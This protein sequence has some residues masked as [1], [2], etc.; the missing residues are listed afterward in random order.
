MRCAE[1]RIVLVVLTVAAGFGHTPARADERASGLKSVLTRDFDLGKRRSPG[2]R[3]FE[4]V[5]TWISF[6]PDGKRA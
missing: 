5:T 4:M 1:I 2:T 3:Y 6:G